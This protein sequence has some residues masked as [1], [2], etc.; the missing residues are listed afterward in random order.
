MYINKLIRY[1]DTAGSW[2]NKALT[3]EDGYS[4]SIQASKYHY[5]IPREDLASNAKYK[6]FEIQTD[7]D[8]IRCDVQSYVSRKELEEEIKWAIKKHGAIRKESLKS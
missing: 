4:I 5:C 3:F 1:Q 2:W 8:A 6:A 7:D